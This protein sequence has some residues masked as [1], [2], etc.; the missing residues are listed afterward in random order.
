L[1]DPAS[2]FRHRNQEVGSVF[3]LRVCCLIGK[4]TMHVAT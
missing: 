4:P 1:C 3:E 2:D